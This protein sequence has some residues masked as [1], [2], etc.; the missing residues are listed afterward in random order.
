MRA[1]SEDLAV[2]DFGERHPDCE[3]HGEEAPGDDG[4]DHFSSSASALSAEVSEPF[5]RK[6]RATF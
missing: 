1:G 6:G 3:N 2:L 5:S 4:F